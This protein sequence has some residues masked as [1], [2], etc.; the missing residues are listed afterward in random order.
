MAS[1][2]SCATNDFS[3]RRNE[4][5][6]AENLQSASD[7]ARH[8]RVI[9]F[10]TSFTN[11]NARTSLH[12]R[13]R[14]N[15]SLRTSNTRTSLYE[16]ATRQ[17]PNLF[18]YP[19]TRN[20][21]NMSAPAAVLPAIVQHD[22][23]LLVSLTSYDSFEVFTQHKNDILWAVNQLVTTIQRDLAVDLKVSGYTSYK[24]KFAFIMSS[25]VVRHMKPC[26]SC[27]ACRR[28]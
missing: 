18:T 5:Q 23:Q 15:F 26:M 20:I 21:P 22:S 14:T 4:H 27:N 28:S 2:S 11:A 9:P 24:N 13:Q 7:Q 3:S 17:H 12:E 25:P 1:G 10:T 16:P 6:L 8:H 19:Q